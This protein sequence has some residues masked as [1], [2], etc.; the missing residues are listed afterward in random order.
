MLKGRYGPYV[1]DGETNATMPEGTDPLTVTLEQALALI[2]ER[3]AERRRQEERRLA[4]AKAAK[5][6]KPGQPKKEPREKAR[7]QKASLR[8]AKHK[9]PRRWRA[10]KR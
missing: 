1:S 7:S 6:K 8:K 10:N 9:S 4:K 5:P 2:A 3:A